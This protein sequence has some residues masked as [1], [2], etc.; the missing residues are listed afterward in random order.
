MPRSYTRK[1]MERPSP[2]YPANDY[3]GQVKRGNDGS[4]WLSSKVGSQSACTWKPVVRSPRRSR[5]AHK[6]LGIPY[7]RT[8]SPRRLR[9]RSPMRPRSRSP[10]R[11]KS[12]KRS[13]RRLKSPKRSPS[14]QKS[15]RYTMSDYH[16]FL[17]SF[18]DSRRR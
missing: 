15:P 7:I 4:M 13:P 16:D 10:R 6:M 11:L 2:P 8:R 5:E 1:Y 18:Y 17:T 9:S 14:R 3:C 12:P